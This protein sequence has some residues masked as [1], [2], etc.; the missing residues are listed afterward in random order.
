MP[1][2]II[3]DI[4]YIIHFTPEIKPLKYIAIGIKYSG[5]EKKRRFFP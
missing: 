1:N 5:L 3:I 4:S 2:I